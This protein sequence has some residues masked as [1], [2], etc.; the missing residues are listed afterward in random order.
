[1]DP[2]ADIFNTGLKSGESPDIYKFEICTPVPKLHP[3]QSIAQ[4]R[5]ISGLFNFDKVYEKLISQ[6]IIS[7]ME[8]K[9]DPG[10]FGN[11][12]GISIQH[13]LIQMIHRI[14]SMLDNNSKG[15]VFAVVASLIDWNNA[16]PRQCPKLGIESFIENGVRPSLI[17]VLVNY[18]QDR[19]MSVKW[20][21]CRSDPKKINGGGPQG[22]TIGLLEYLSQS[23]SS[24]DCVDLEDR[25]KFVDDLS[26]LEIVNLLTV[27]IT[28]YNLK[29]TVPSDIP[30]HNQFIPPNNLQ[31]QGWLDDID[32][33][34]EN[35]QMVIN[36]KKTKTGIFN[37]TEKYQFT[38]RLKL[39]NENV[40]VINNTRLLGTILSDDMRWD[41][42]TKNMVKKANARMELLRRVA[43]FGTPVEDL[44]IVYILFIRSILEQSATVW[45]S[46]CTEENSSD[47]E[48]V[49][50][51]AVKVMLQ[52]Q[53]NGYQNGLAKLGLENLNQRRENLCLEFAKKCTKHE[54][55]QHMF[56]KHQ[57]EHSM[58]TRYNE[59]YKVQ[60]ANTSRL[61][62]SAIIYMQKLLNDDELTKQK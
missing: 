22:A 4:L 50:K 14:L 33:W 20:H 46:S 10:Q 29:H 9:L 42:N 35:Q 3:T 49:Q 15:D 40:D 32:R 36:E 51:S 41:V 56:P 25:F 48:R 2:L 5:N 13:Y 27:G 23:N 1:V 6:L 26:I 16:F 60:H 59:V 24:A 52:D 53:Y 17:P 12:K 55:L 37:F 44:K 57:K 62:N 61:Q 47:L 38:T 45:H 7:D 43:S 34:T 28:S 11:Q 39:K 19:T 18:F 31:S 58:E 54:K 8:A 21:G 30:C